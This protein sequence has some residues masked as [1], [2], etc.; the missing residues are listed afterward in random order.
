MDISAANKDFSKQHPRYVIAD[1]GK[2]VSVVEELGLAHFLICDGM[3]VDAELPECTELLI[4]NGEYILRETGETLLER[5]DTIRIYPTMIVS[6]KKFHGS[7]FRPSESYPDHPHFYPLSNFVHDRLTRDRDIKPETIVCPVTNLE[8]PINFECL[9]GEVHK[10]QI[11]GD[12][13][14]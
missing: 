12:E 6:K 2:V 1:H 7:I 8:V 11:N 4:E 3:F 10:Q 9:C 13:P 14:E 5:K